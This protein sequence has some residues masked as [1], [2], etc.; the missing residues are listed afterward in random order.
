MK[1]AI[2][3]VVLLLFFCSCHQE[4][5]LF[6]FV[7]SSH[8]GITFNN[9][10]QESDSLN[11]V[12]LVN[13]YNGGGVGIG[14][15]N[16]DGLPDIYFTGNRVP[17]RLYINK[18]RLKF[19][20]VTAIA[21]VE[22]E[23]KWCSGVSV[24]DI[25]NDGL[26]DIYV[27][28]TIK[29]LPSQRK[30]MLYVNKGPG[31]DGIPRF[32]DMAREYGLDDSCHSVQ[33]AFFD[34]DN[35]GD[36]DMYLGVNEV[37]ESM[38]RFMNHS[39]VRNSNNPST[40]RLFRNDWN[41]SLKH[42][43]FV[44]VSSS[45]GVN[46]E[47]YANAVY[48]SDIN[49]DGWKD[50]YVSN[51]FL[52]SDL[53][54]INNHDG[55]FTDKVSVY[56]K[57]I[58][59]NAMGCDM[60]DVNNDGLLDMVELDMNP[61]DNLRRKTMLQ[62][63][64][65]LQF[66]NGEGYTQQYSRNTLQLNQGPRI[67]E[68][69]SIGDPIFSDIGYFAG[70]AATDWSWGPLIADFDHDGNADIIIN[71]GFPKDV[72]DRDFSVFRNRFG[73]ALP[74]DHLLSQIPE[75][76][77]RKYAF[78]NKGNLE[79]E[80]VSEKWGFTTP[81]FTNG[82]AYADLDGDGDLDLVLN[83]IND[84]AFLYENTS[85][86][87]KNEKSHFLKVRL[88]GPVNNKNGIGSWVELYYD[89]GKKQVWESNPYKGYLSTIE[90]AANFGLGEINSIDSVIVRWPDG[91][92]QKIMQPPTDQVLVADISQAQGNLPFEQRLIASK[93]LFRNVTS[94]K[95]L[96]Y[97]DHDPIP[98]DFGYQHI[99]PHSYSEYGP[100]LAAGDLNGDGLDD[101]ICGGASYQSAEVFFQHADGNFTHEPLVS[102]VK[103]K[104][105]KD[106]GLLL[107]DADGDGDP[108]LYI[109]SGGYENAPNTAAYQDH[110]Y[111]NDG[112][113]KFREIADALPQVY[114]SKLNV[115]A[116]DF[117][118]DGDLDLFVSGRI[119]PR[120]YPKPVSCVLLRNDSGNGK[121]KF[122]EVT[123][124]IAPDLLNIGLVSDALFSDFD[125]DGWT[126][127]LLAGEWMPLVFLKNDHGSFK[128]VSPA[129]GINGQVGWWNSLVS[130]DF[131]NDGDIDYIAGNLGLNTYYKAS[132]QY[133]VRVYAGDFTRSERYL[134]FLSQYYPVSHQDQTMKEFPA[135][136][137]DDV[138][139]QMNS[140]SRKFPDYKSFG[141][142]QMKDLFSE[143]QMK[144]I[145]I[146]KANNFS[147]CYIENK[148]NG[149]F[150]MH[151]LPVEA[152]IALLNGM[153]A[154]DFNGDGNLDVLLTGNQ[155]GME[156]TVGRYDAMNGLLL[157]GDGKGGFI[158]SPM[159]ESGIFL[160][161]NCKAIIMLRSAR[162]QPLVVASCHNGPLA[163]FEWQIKGKFI[164]IAPAET[165]A[166]LQAGP[167]K[168]K[169]E[170]NWGNSFLSQSSRFITTGESAT[171]EI[172]GDGNTKRIVKF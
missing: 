162:Q 82:T 107:F 24:V 113:G 15:F 100:A 168:R 88:K 46:T 110:F 19:R 105:S 79:F 85:G 80:K 54:W 64:K 48:I 32:T 33:A 25:N 78:K 142:A 28:A 157:K 51:D 125:N 120:K 20:D 47:S 130:G 109:A 164:D 22:G 146:L 5:P 115:K 27:C 89:H 10:I 148:G 58:T 38:Y 135:Q 43:V 49:R 81:A 42:P 103:M 123:S 108:D 121:I 60:G 167:L 86:E 136:A 30:N 16:N 18:G 91:K 31:S 137:R 45:A 124:T 172:S 3:A 11:A 128:N 68:N 152:Q 40:G 118:Q 111:V 151:R 126:D 95:K 67:G 93:T 143:D 127:L 171:V 165:S 97:F 166:V 92:F 2:P 161:G 101:F 21:G 99:L 1:Y 117:D 94:E 34:Y 96:K 61:E 23:G 150:E 36:L 29:K 163:A 41:D 133:P 160:P 98:N 9:E 154:D 144:D 26:L 158:S 159:A 59:A 56:F 114:T 104:I 149:L 155:Y 83:N 7:K 70:I 55:T 6:H 141:L 169:V 112:R 71:N 39:P 52:V 76:K 75:V 122:T 72:T 66:T 8:S 57:H 87:T 106:A 77:L 139:M 131:D 90:N 73:M 147:S 170:F 14:D 84:K 129:S 69:D 65:D 119:E 4:K 138:M 35:D 53:L 17:C 145:L 37:T 140:L 132:D 134:A 102:G 116:A 74:K 12:D 62:S 44:N 153:V 156:E 63:N 50:I 13:V